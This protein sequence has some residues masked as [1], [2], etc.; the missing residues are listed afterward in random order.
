MSREV[1]VVGA[2]A[3]SA[4]SALAWIV[5]VETLEDVLGRDLSIV[6]VIVQDE[7]T[8]DVVT[9]HETHPEDVHVVFD[10]T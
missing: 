5:E 10:T 4:L 2:V 3:P 9:R 6:E 7:Y 8:H 1:R